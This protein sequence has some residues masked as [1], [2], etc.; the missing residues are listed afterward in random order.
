MSIFPTQDS[1]GPSSTASAL[2]STVT[3]AATTA[4]AAAATAATASTNTFTFPDSLDAQALFD[5]LLPLCRSISGKGYDQSLA[6]LSRYIPFTIEEYPSGSKAFDWTVPPRWELERAVLKDS[7]GQVLLDSDVSALYVLNYSEPFSGRVSKQELEEHLYSDATRPDLVPYVMSYYKPRWGFCLS[8]K[9]RQELLKDDFYEVDIKTRKVQGAIKVGVCELKGKSDRIV[10]FSSYLCHPNMLNNELSGPIAL[11]YLYQM[12]RAYPEREYTYRFVINPETIGSICYLSRHFEELKERLEY[13]VVLTCV[14]SYYA[15]DCQQGPIAPLD[16]RELN[17]AT[18]AQAQAQSQDGTDF[19]KLRQALLAQLRASL[20]PNYLEIPISFKLSH[21]SLLDGLHYALQ[22]EGES[23]SQEQDRVKAGTKEATQTESASCSSTQEPESQLDY[24]NNQVGDVNFAN[25][26]FSTERSLSDQERIELFIR[27]QQ[28][29]SNKYTAA[30]HL[31]KR[32]MSADKFMDFAYSQRIDRFVCGLAKTSKQQFTLRPFSLTG[33]DE[34][35]YGSSLVNLPVVQASRVTYG[36]YPEYH[37]SG[38]NQDLFSL[39]S[40][41][42]SAITLFYCA[43]LY[44]KLDMQPRVSVGCEPQ[45][46][47]RGLYPDLHSNVEDRKQ[48][49]QNFL[50]LD[51]LLSVLSFSDGSFSFAELCQVLDCS[52]L[53][54][55]LLMELLRYH[56]LVRY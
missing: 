40:I 6:I 53:E 3:T 14:A 30:T 36:L 33:S 23:Q 24:A 45:L 27:H 34:R 12:L 7:H 54:L 41:I 29:N 16:L 11:V 28:A 22:L 39:D 10:Q 21:Q 42:D 35:Q 49:E 18:Q 2:D 31:L 20:N 13:G 56:Q 17:R 52:P 38:D 48:L 15:N 26:I 43:Q 4:A 9:Q 44:E 1:S 47:K 46:G 5:E 32:H 51:R 37:S 50:Q 55:F 19:F 8:H 25:G